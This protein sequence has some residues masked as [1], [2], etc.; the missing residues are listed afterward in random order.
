MCCCVRCCGARKRPEPE[1]D[2]SGPAARCAPG[3]AGL[4]L[5]PRTRNSRQ[6]AGECRS[7]YRYESIP[8][9]R[10]ILREMGLFPKYGWSLSMI[11]RAW[12]RWGCDGRPVAW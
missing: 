1:R 4:G 2:G 10:R 11:R 7:M 9:V 3:R 5:A 8:N 12:R 6:V